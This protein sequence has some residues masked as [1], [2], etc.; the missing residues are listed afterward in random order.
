MESWQGCHK[1]KPDQQGDQDKKFA[2]FFKLVL[3]Y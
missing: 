2:W 3:L 1:D